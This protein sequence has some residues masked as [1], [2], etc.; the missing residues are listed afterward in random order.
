MRSSSSPSCR[1]GARPRSRTVIYLAALQDVPHE[2]VEAA[3]ID[4]AGSLQVTWRVVWPQLRP[5]T[6]FVGVYLTLQ[7]LQLFDLVYATTRGGPLDATQ[8]IVYLVWTTAF[9]KPAVRVRLG[10]RLRPVR[11]QP[12][13]DG[14]RD[15]TQRRAARR[16]R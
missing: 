10:H 3:R 5:V 6:T 11:A 15:V 4:G 9:Q 2:T 12:R 7:A 16:T 1:C 14:R 8:T 13:R